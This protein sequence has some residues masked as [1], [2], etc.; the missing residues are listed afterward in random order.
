MKLW[1]G[2]ILEKG[3][4]DWFLMVI[5]LS[6]TVKKQQKYNGSRRSQYGS[7]WR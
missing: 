4:D 7:F 2:Y 3:I 1:K 5:Y 6:S